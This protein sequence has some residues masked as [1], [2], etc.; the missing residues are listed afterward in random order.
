MIAEAS[1][2]KIRRRSVGVVFLVVLALL[3]WLSVAI[4]DK[5]FTPVVSVALETD[6]AGNEMH[7]H[8]EVKVRGVVVGEVRQIASTGDGARLELA[9]QPDMVNRLPANV[10]A[11][12]LPTTLFG[13]RY[14]DLVLPA[15]PDP[16]RLVAGSVIG[17]DRSQDAIE[18]QKVLSD[19]LPML[20]AVQPQ[21]LAVTLTAIST[22]L[23][24]RGTELGTTLA[25][26]NSYLAQFNPQLP[27][28]DTD[29]SQL[30]NVADD[31]DA[32][33]PDLV[34]A[35][36]DFSRTSQTVVAERD[37][38]STLYTT[39]TGTSQDLT[40]FLTQNKDNI[41]RLNADARPALQI[42]AKYSSEFPCTLQQL[43]NFEPAVDRVLG[44]G[45][46]RPGLQ[47]SLH[48]VP[49]LGRYVPGRDTPKFDDN[50]GPHCYPVPFGGVA[51]HDGTTPA[52][53]A[54]A[55]RAGT[56][57]PA[58]DQS[59]PTGVLGLANSPAENEFVNELVAPSVNQPPQALPDWSSVLVGPVFRGTEVTLK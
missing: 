20:T 9:I 26:I 24:D 52:V 40:D 29:I 31:F 14:V 33:A 32:A 48:P 28:L 19:L 37:N 27:K 18:L 22:A 11:E 34:Q 23:Q 3:V 59:T 7:P 56:Q 39:L 38:L 53:R 42:L 58:A 55:V 47:V 36:N 1:W 45:T 44:K 8:A 30:A 16:Q 57:V 15:D 21:K 41:I 25:Q 13:E 46:N 17:E 51:L 2:I 10:S 6:S 35:L 5:Q 4:Y 50:S 54:P 12:L 43:V 49:S